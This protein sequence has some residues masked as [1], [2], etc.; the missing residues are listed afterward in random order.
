M[1]RSCMGSWGEGS[2]R[3]LSSFDKQLWVEGFGALQTKAYTWIGC[4]AFKLRMQ[5]AD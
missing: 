4:L 2:H 1:L 3:P 5:I